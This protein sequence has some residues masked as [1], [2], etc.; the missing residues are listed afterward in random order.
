M[1]VPQIG[2][3]LIGVSAGWFSI[4]CADDQPATTADPQQALSTWMDSRFEARWKENHVKPPAIVD[5]PTFL[6]R[7]YLDLGGTIPSV[8]QTLDFLSDQSTNKRE[9]MV[10][11]LLA[12][13]RTPKHLARVWRRMMVPGNG[14]ESA[15][16][17][18]LLEP[19]LIEQFAANTHYDE[20]ARRVLVVAQPVAP[21]QPLGLPG[22]QAPTPSAGAYMQAVGRTPDAVAGASTRFF[23][24]VSLN[25]AKCH[26]HPFAK[27]KQKDFWGMAAFFANPGVAGTGQIQSEQG[28]TYKTVFLGGEEATI[29]PDKQAPEVLVDWMTSPKNTN[30]GATAVNRVWQHLYGR[31]AVSEI[32]DLDRVSAEER[33]FFL[34]ELG[35]KFAAA[36]YDLRWLIASL[37]KSRTYQR[38][39]PGKSDSSQTDALTQRPLKTLLPEQVFDSLEQALN[40]PVGKSDDS[41]RTNGTRTQ[42]VAKLN[43][44]ATNHPDQFRSGIPQALMLMH[45]AMISNATDLETSRTLRAVIEAPFLEPKQKIETLYMAALTRKPRDQ[46]LKV[47]LSFVKEQ[48]EPQLQKQAYS[49]IFWALLNSPEFVLSP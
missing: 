28:Q 40:L 9:K 32:D 10:D 15:T 13:P 1:K 29:P 12:D 36:D 19:W 7:I 48:D 11:Q 47:M 18:V 17:T 3:L 30:F 4:A 37:C 25:C 20:L 34:D 27:W 2:I 38:E 39:T 33:A 5:D 35:Q 41:P 26:D 21:M 6:R 44:A 45:G 31:G 8:S 42:M 49:E 24:G 46:E 22:Q 23:L 43:E 14:P 16:A